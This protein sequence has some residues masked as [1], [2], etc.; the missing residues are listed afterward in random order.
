MNVYIAIKIVCIS[1]KIK[2]I[3]K[4]QHI[5]INNVFIFKFVNGLI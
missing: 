4:N 1:F 3:V 5:N 2:N